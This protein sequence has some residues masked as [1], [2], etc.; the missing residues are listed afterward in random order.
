MHLQTIS[1]DDHAFEYDTQ[2]YINV[3]E[4][5]YRAAAIIHVS[6]YVYLIYTSILIYM[7]TVMPRPAF[8]NP[9]T[10]TAGRLDHSP[11]KMLSDIV[12]VLPI[13]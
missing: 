3:H 8:N 13:A 10:F 4:A 2:L 1:A 12:P 5:I 7:Y 11:A 9:V 6:R